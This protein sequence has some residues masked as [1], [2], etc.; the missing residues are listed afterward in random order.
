M[1]E[2]SLRPPFDRFLISVTGWEVPRFVW[3]LSCNFV[4]GFQ[5][6]MVTHLSA[7]LS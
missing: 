5:L 7:S 2:G 1:F 6:Y 3:S 4:L